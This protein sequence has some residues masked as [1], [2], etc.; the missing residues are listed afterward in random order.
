MS[1]LTANFSVNWAM[2]AVKTTRLKNR[3]SK[4]LRECQGVLVCS[5]EECP[6]L[7]RP[8]TTALLLSSQLNTDLCPIQTCGLPLRHVECKAKCTIIKYGDN[9]RLFEHIGFHRHRPPPNLHLTPT[10]RTEFNEIVQ[11]NPTRT[12]V[13][14]ITGTSLDGPGRPVT[15]L[16]PSLNNV[17]R[18]A[19]YRRGVMNGGDQPRRGGDKFVDAITSFMEKHPGFIVFL[20]FAP[21]ALIILQTEFMASL[22]AKE[23]RSDARNGFVTDSHFSFFHADNRYLFVTGTFSTDLNAWVPVMYAYSGGQSEEEYRVYFYTLF[24]KMHKKLGTKVDIT[25]DDLAQVRIR[26]VVFIFSNSL[27]IFLGCRL[28]SSPAK[29]FH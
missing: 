24:E 13:Q 18:V 2:N 1:L 25:D 4:L 21:S 28:F 8:K 27:T 15:S 17:D 3:S 12:P 22:M 5:G 7:V 19:Y 26:R 6:G 10:Q 20:R 9:S 16:D 14:L 23:A 29:W 11:S